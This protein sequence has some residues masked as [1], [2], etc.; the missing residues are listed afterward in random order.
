[1]KIVLVVPLGS[2]AWA[3]TVL[4]SVF[5]GMLEPSTSTTVC[6]CR[7][8]VLFAV[9]LE[10]KS[11]SGGSE[12]RPDKALLVSWNL[13]PK[14]HEVP[15][16]EITCTNY[17]ILKTYGPSSF[18]SDSRSVLGAD[19]FW[20]KCETRSSKQLRQQR[21]GLTMLQQAW[22]NGLIQQVHFRPGSKWNLQ[23]GT[24][25]GFCSLA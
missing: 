23:L 6:K 18:E 9:N 15:T 20:K 5:A 25:R 24:S 14:H 21:H 13:F 17:R 12:P 22:S 10:Q 3:Q 19:T 8:H 7:K 2:C 4:S 11:A 1:M 16:S